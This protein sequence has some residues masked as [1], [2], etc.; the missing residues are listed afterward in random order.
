MDEPEGDDVSVPDGVTD[1][2]PLCSDDESVNE[3]ANDQEAEPSIDDES[4]GVP[5]DLVALRAAGLS[6]SVAVGVAERDCEL[7]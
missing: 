2:V 5:T 6:E 1:L 3:C 7:S 4:V